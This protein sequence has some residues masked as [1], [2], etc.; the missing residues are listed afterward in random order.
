[1]DRRA[2]HHKN[3][4]AHRKGSQSAME[5]LITYS[6]A[7]LIMAIVLTLMFELN[8]FSLSEKALPG[9]CR[10]YRVNGPYSLL[11]INLEGICRDLAPEFMMNF[12]GSY[13]TGGVVRSGNGKGQGDITYPSY[14]SVGAIPEVENGQ[15][16]TITAW[17]DWYGASAGN[18]QGIFGSDPSPGDGFALWGYGSDNGKCSPFW[19]DGSYDHWPGTS[20]AFIQGRLTFVAAVYNQSSG[21]GTVYENGD[22]FATATKYGTSFNSLAPLTIGGIIGPNSDVYAFNGVV[23]NVQLY[24]R[25]LSPETLN[26]MYAEGVGGDPI[27]LNN[28]VG[29]WPLNGNANDYSGNNNNGQA[30]N[31]LQAV[32]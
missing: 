2:R 22:V 25:T 10:V 18:C 21:R 12:G 5:Y 15:G 4:D 16:F 11:G 1:M 26:A 13:A 29:W 24:N 20:N 19:V 9:L 17:V 7:I 27:V 28:L 31:T 23:T 8:L 32:R 30:Y 6:W 3:S 14:V